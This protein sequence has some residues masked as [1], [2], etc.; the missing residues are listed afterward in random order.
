M[1]KVSCLKCNKE[2]SIADG[3]SKAFCKYCGNQLVLN[4]SVNVITCPNCQ[5]VNSGS[6]L[7]FCKCC[8]NKLESGK[9]MNESNTATGTVI[10]C[11]NCAAPV[12][13]ILQDG[14][15]K[16][17]ICECCGTRIMVDYQAQQA[18]EVEKAKLKA[19][20]EAQRTLLDALTEMEEAALNI[21]D[22]Y[23]SNRRSEQTGR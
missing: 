9:P 15:G 18:Y 20:E 4:S 10:V 16:Y 13:T 22:N 2:Q 1:R 14:Y 7:R 21:N 5:T 17:A 6:I 19:R 8:G 11:S 12:K 3:I 23:K